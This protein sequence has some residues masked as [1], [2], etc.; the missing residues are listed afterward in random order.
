MSVVQITGMSQS[1][2][3]KAESDLDMFSKL[4]E[5]QQAEQPHKLMED[6]Y[7]ARNRESVFVVTP[8]NG[9]FVLLDVMEAKENMRAEMVKRGT[10]KGLI[11]TRRGRIVPLE[12]SL[13]G[14][15]LTRGPLG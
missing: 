3:K 8:K 10:F 9:S 13:L 1:F 12:K 2:A 6:I 11:E 14:S 4:I 15:V 7:L 5:L